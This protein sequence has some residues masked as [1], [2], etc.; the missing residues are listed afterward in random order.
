MP[1]LE[2][3]QETGKL[4]SWKKKEG[5]QVRKGEMLLEVETDKAV[6]EIEAAGDGIL[7]GVTAKVGDV[8]PVGQTIAW[9]LQPGEAPPAAAAPAQTGRKMDR[10]RP[11]PPLQ[12]RRQ[13]GRAPRPA[14]GAPHLAESATARARTRR[15]PQQRAR[16]GPGRRDPRRRHPE[17]RAVPRPVRPAAPPAAAPTQARPPAGVPAPARRSA[18]SAAHGRADDAELDDGSAFLRHARRRR[19]RAQRARASG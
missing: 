8:V 4:V 14:A 17:G 1:A 5:E 11:R 2:M 6:V 16:V 18:R 19:H 3:A 9:L 15:R 13:L 10:R 12:P 7:A